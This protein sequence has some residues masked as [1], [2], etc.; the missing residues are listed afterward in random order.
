MKAD[1]SFSAA[2]A[3]R[4]RCLHSHAL[5]LETMFG[6]VQGSL[7]SLEL[8]VSTSRSVYGLARH[9]GTL[10]AVIGCSEEL[11]YIFSNPCRQLSPASHTH[12]PPDRPMTPHRAA[13]ARIFIARILTDDY[14]VKIRIIC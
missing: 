10:Y 13:P 5:R 6:A 1:P 12:F 2:S 11:S 3:L 4:T 9:V 7:L 14:L 8:V